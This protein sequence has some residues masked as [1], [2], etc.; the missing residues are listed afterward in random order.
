MFVV[1]RGGRGATQHNLRPHLAAGG[2]GRRV[3][4][5]ASKS[6]GRGRNNGGKA[7][8]ACCLNEGG[9]GGTQKE[10]KACIGCE[11]RRAVMSP[12]RR[13]STGES[14]NYSS[15][16]PTSAPI[17]INREVGFDRFVWG[18]IV[19]GF[20]FEGVFFVFFLLRC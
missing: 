20:M 13:A 18:A 5:I 14:V 10:R 16:L 9:G 12:K 1:W 2:Q 6:A 15:S 11:G 19:A 8:S 17:P 4:R 3:S 7:K